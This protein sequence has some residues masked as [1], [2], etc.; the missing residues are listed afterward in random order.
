MVK[1]LLEDLWAVTSSRFLAD[2]LLGITPAGLQPVLIVLA[3]VA[4]TARILR[5]K[6]N[7][8]KKPQAPWTGSE[9]FLAIGPGFIRAGWRK[10][11][12]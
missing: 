11:R 3:S 10:A 1:R 4:L 7:A 2:E 12:R 5:R 6:N 8:P 9:F